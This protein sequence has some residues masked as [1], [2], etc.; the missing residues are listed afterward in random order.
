VNF[1][2]LEIAFV[3]VFAL[4]VFG[5]KRLPGLAR[6]VGAAMREFK[7]ATQDLTEDLRIEVEDLGQSKSEPPQQ[8]PRPGPRP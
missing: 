7:K 4:I 1:G 5:P 2:P 8:E 3:A 6:S